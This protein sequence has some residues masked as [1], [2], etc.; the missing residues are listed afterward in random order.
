[1]AVSLLPG[2]QLDEMQAMTIAA[3]GNVNVANETANA[4]A[5]LYNNLIPVVNDARNDVDLVMATNTITF[6]WGT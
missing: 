3:A 4:A 5:T 2:R 6:S 1:M